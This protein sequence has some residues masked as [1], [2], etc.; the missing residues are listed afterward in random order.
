MISEKSGQLNP[1]QPGIEEINTQQ[2]ATR[3][4]VAL[5]GPTGG[6]SIGERLAPP[7]PGISVTRRGTNSV[8]PIGKPDLPASP[9]T[10]SPGPTTATGGKNQ[11]AANPEDGLRK[12]TPR[13]GCIPDVDFSRF[14]ADLQRRIKQAWFPPKDTESLRIKVQF[15]AHRN[16]SMGNLRLIK[17]SG[18]ALADQAALRAVQNAAPF[19]PLPEGAPPSVDIEF[20][21]DYNVYRGGFGGSRLRN[22]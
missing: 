9:G 15:V 6:D 12:G 7:T 11:T 18:N 2:K 3:G 8:G 16:G 13:H 21:F 17:S 22:W 19:K 5:K 20:T 1:A 4:P 10:N 14:M